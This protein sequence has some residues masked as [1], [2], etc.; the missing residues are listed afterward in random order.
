MCLY[1][2]KTNNCFKFNLYLS[3]LFRFKRMNSEAFFST[4]TFIFSC[5]EQIQ[6]TGDSK[7]TKY[8]TIVRFI[9]TLLS[10]NVYIRFVFLQFSGGLEFPHTILLI[11][12]LQGH[13][14]IISTIL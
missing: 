3:V 12:C 2:L 4:L 6:N 14:V 8:F 11:L 10:L 9:L 1:V 13:E 7:C 5:A